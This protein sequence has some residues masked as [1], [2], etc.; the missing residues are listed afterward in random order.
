MVVA[1]AFGAAAACSPSSTPR[2]APP[3]VGPVA[4]HAITKADAAPGSSAAVAAASTEPLVDPVAPAP[5]G[6]SIARVWAD[7]RS[8][9]G[10]T[11]TIRGKVVKFNADI[12]GFD[13]TH[14]QDGSG[15][16]ADGT[17]DITVTSPPTGAARVGDVV[18]VTGTVTLDKDFGAG[19]AYAV[20]L[21]NATIA[22]K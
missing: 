7:R 22:V 14:V 11:V 3:G 8:L 10:R 17:H 12:L 5:G 4:S 16:P 9:A 6:I 19:Y 20:M 18:T 21:Q 15:V 2:P 13:W 1:A